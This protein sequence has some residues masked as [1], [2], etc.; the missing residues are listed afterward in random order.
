MAA[1][2]KKE[3]SLGFIIGA[4]L[5]SSFPKA[6]QAAEKQILATQKAVKNAGKAWGEFGKEAASLALKVTGVATALT[7]VVWK[8]TDSVANQAIAVGRNASQLRM[9]T[10][11]YQRLAYAFDEAGIGADE[12]TSMMTR[13][14]MRLLDASETAEKIT[15]FGEEFGLDA[16]KLAKL[17]PEERIKILSD[18]LNDLEDP[19]RR[20]RL[21]M[22]LFGKSGAEM[23]RVLEM[24]SSGMAEAANRFE[25][26]GNKIGDETIKQANDY[27]TMRKNLKDTI[28]GIKV[29]MFGGLLPAFTE[30]FARIAEKLQSV[31]WA[32][33]GQKLAQWV[34]NA[35]PKIIEIAQKIGD[36][37]IKIK[38]GIVAV[39][40]FVGGWGN[41]AKFAGILLI[42]PTAIKLI[43][44]LIATFKAFKA[45]T[46]LLAGNPIILIIMAIIVGLVL[47]IK[48]FDKVNEFVVKFFSAI[49][50]F[51]SNAWNKITGFFTGAW[52]KIKAVWDKVLGFF[53]AI[54][55]GIKVAFFAVD[56]FFG[57][58]FT[59]AW[60]KIKENW[61]AVKDFFAGIWEAIK[62]VFG[63]IADWF[64]NIFSNAWQAIKNVFSAGG[65]VFSGIKDGIVNALK[66]VINGIITGLNTVIAIP[67]NGLN[68]AL[69]RL[70]NLSIAGLKPFGWLPQIPVPQIPY[71]ARGG[72]VDEE[73]TAVIGEAGPEAVVPLNDKPRSREIWETAGRMAGFNRQGAG[74]YSISIGAPT[75]SIAGNADAGTVSRLRD[76]AAG[77]T[78]DIADAV[79]RVIE[80]NKR[81]EAR[82][83]YR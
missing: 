2:K 51:I 1:S 83:A 81:E 76:A 53:S 79:Q 52:D 20:D 36:F 59:K 45:V 48:H 70:R 77:M 25:A 37:I 14:D 71:L 21:A 38:N 13:L 9:S 28:N 64:K 30:V 65:E 5:K 78:Q 62:S 32:E 57:G 55:E 15:A 4:Q 63:G 11:E 34:E 22:E 42:L 50:G 26:T 23:R 72:I 35:I 74:G 56:E 17:A 44:A 16:G 69:D 12:F 73:T 39:K 68:N 18:Y 47:L 58:I 27:D 24:G 82:L 61:S 41:M 10:D 66:A 54:W 33:M 80:A 43:T 19:L 49:T 6:F 8:L 60:E 67:L 40:D 29:Q 46:A 3:Y 31:D 7:T 75:I